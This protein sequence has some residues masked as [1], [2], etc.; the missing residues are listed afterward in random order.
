M[1]WGESW[2]TIL[3]SSN[4]GHGLTASLIYHNYDEM[5]HCTHVFSGTKMV[6][7]SAE[8]PTYTSRFTQTNRDQ[9]ILMSSRLYLKRT[10]QME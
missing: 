9:N 1:S 2:Q 6:M 3:T 7:V 8:T 5:N 10:Q 4:A